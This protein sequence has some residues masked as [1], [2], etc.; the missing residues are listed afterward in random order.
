MSSQPDVKFIHYRQRAADGTVSPR[1][2][3]TIAFVEDGDRVLSAASKCHNNDNFNRKLGRIRASGRL[4]SYDYQ[5]EFKG[6]RAEFL[7]EM[8]GQVALYNASYADQ[9]LTREF[10][11]RRPKSQTP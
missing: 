10:S 2:G 9:F 5:V 7:A 11:Q 6:T 3:L 4:R 8:D 1:G